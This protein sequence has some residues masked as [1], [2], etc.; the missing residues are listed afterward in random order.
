M[1]SPIKNLVNILRNNYNYDAS[2]IFST[3]QRQ[4]AV[5]LFWFESEEKGYIFRFVDW[6]M[7]IKDFITIQ[8]MY[9]HLD[10]LIKTLDLTIQEIER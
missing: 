10:K 3:P 6:E 9:K 2:I 8:A 5:S 7:N 1:K 4:D